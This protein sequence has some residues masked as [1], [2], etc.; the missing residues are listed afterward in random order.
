MAQSER[1]QRFIDA[2]NGLKLRFPGREIAKKTGYGKGTVSSYL[3]NLEPS[4]NFIKTF[5]EKFEVS[6]VWVWFGKT[7][8]KAPAGSEP[9]IQLTEAEPSPMQIL[10]RLSIAYKDQA[11]ALADQAAGFRAQAEGFRTLTETVNQMRNEMARAN[12]QA[13]LQTNLQRV[14]GGVETIGDRQ[15]QY[16]KKILAD[17]AE[18]KKK[19]NTLS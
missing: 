6:F 3:T 5:C 1:H 9:L 2:V 19:Q 4:E 18:I 15:E 17:L 8:E 7:E 14:F 16:I 13:D 11:K 10:D 12:A